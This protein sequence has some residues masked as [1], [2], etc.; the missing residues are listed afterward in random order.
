MI[1]VTLQIDVAAVKAALDR[2]DDPHL[3]SIIAQAIADEDV[4]PALQ[5]YPPQSRKPQPFVSAQQRR[6]FFAKLR[7]GEISVPYHRTGRTG[8][9]YTKQ[10]IPDGVVVSSSLPSAAYTRGPGQ[11]AYHKGTWP[12]HET[13]AQQLEGDAAL[14][15][16]GVI[17]KAIGDAGP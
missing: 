13:L 5:K 8:S 4:I 9:S 16:T 12:T 2:L 6:A 1:D 11:A 14:T 17:V 15:A 7:S 3:P 10:A